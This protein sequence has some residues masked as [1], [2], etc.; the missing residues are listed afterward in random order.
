MYDLF[1]KKSKN[2]HSYITLIP[3]HKLLLKLDLDTSLNYDL[4]RGFHDRNETSESKPPSQNLN[5]NISGL[6]LMTPLYLL[7]NTRDRTRL[8]RRFI[9]VLTLFYILTNRHC[10]AAL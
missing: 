4:I 6:N 2:I 3:N 10:H 9:K 1:S 5:T 7:F 8:E